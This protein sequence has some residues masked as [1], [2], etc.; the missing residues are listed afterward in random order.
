MTRKTAISAAV[1]L[2]VASLFL[3][4]RA[5]SGNTETVQAHFLRC[6]TTPWFSG[7]FQSRDRWWVV[8]GTPAD[9]YR[10]RDVTG[11]ATYVND[12]RATFAEDGG[13]AVEFEGSAKPALVA[14]PLDP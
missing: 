13:P 9:Q 2:A 7:S 1:V 12:H 4:V 5:R 10:G 11:T 14:C 8:V 6:D 3:V